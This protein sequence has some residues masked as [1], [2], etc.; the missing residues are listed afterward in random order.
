[1][2]G[3]SIGRASA[4]SKCGCRRSRVQLRQLQLMCKHR[5]G[6]PYISYTSSKS[7]TAIPHKQYS[8]HWILA[9]RLKSSISMAKNA[10][11]SKENRAPLSDS[12]NTNSPL[13]SSE[14]PPSDDPIY[15][16][17]LFDLSPL[18]TRRASD[19]NDRLDPRRTT[20]EPIPQNDQELLP[21][22]VHYPTILET[23]TEVQSIEPSIATGGKQSLI[24][25]FS[26]DDIRNLKR[27]IWKSSS[28]S[29]CSRF[30]C[31]PRASEYPKEP[32]TLPPDRS[33]T[34]PN[35]PTFNTPQA[36]NYR[37]P[38]P[39]LS[40]REVLHIS[41]PRAYQDWVRQTSNLP[42]GAIMRNEDGVIVRG[43]WRAMPS[44]H[45]GSARHPTTPHNDPFSPSNASISRAL[46]TDPD[47][48]LRE[49]EAMERDRQQYQQGIRERKGTWIRFCEISCCFCCRDDEEDLEA[50]VEGAIPVR[51]M[52]AV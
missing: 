43:R 28:S 44:G 45:T 38:P 32:H 42:R 27:K 13:G 16:A 46:G 19:E 17:A 34:P 5:L 12:T 52:R 51:R 33:P 20:S 4:T 49:L 9:A 40:L 22:D 37:L 18:S 7:S 30:T 15:N 10:S 23:I 24:R 3:R 1:M 6:V 21:L 39:D 25:S 50:G 26:L 8:Y 47:A 11:T 35:L 2:A 48:A 31:L 29:S 36:A 41:S 14:L